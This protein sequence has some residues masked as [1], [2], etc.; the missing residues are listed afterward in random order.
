MNAPPLSRRFVLGT[1]LAALAVA[2]LALPPASRAQQV[3]RLDYL[4]DLP[5]LVDREVFFG[6]PETA[7]GQISPDGEHV[8]FLQEKDGVLNVWVKGFG[9]PF[10]AA[11][12][13]TA[14]TTRPVRAYFW[15]EDGETILYAQDKGG[16][17]DFHVYAVDPDGEPEPDTGVPAATDL[18]PYEDV[19]ARI[20][21][22]PENDPRHVIVGINDRDA[23]VHDV[24]RVDIETGERELVRRNEEGVAGWQTDLEGNLRLAIRIDEEGNTEIS[25]VEPDSL[26]VVYTCSPEE[27][28]GPIRFHVDGE[29]VYMV[30]NKG[31]PDLMRLVLFDP[32]TGETELVEEDPEGEVDFGG[33]LFS[34]ETEQLIATSYEDERTRWYPKDPAFERD[35]ERARAEFGDA[36][37][38]F[39]SMTEDG[40]FMLVSVSSDVAPSSTWT[41]DRESGE[42]ELLYRTR[43]DVPAGDMAPMEAVTYTARDGVEIPAFLTLPKGVEAENLAVVIHPHGGPWARDFWGYDGTVQF[44]ANR[45]YAVL[46]PNFRG[47]AGYG[48]RFLNL[49]N[50]EWGTGDMQHDITDGVEWL[51][52]RGVADPDRV[53]I[54]GGSYG[55]Y[56]TLAGLAFT[57]EL[58]AAGVDI[59]GPSSIITLLESIPP[60]W[61]PIQAIF[62]VRVGDPED[63]EDRER[64][65]AQSPLHFAENITAP[66][67]VIQGENDP[68]VKKRESDQI[69]TTL[70]DLGR[71]VEYM[72]APDEGH[73]FANDD[74]R[75]AMYVKIEEFLAEHLGGRYQPDAPPEIEERLAT[76]MVEVDTLTVQELATAEGAERIEAFD[77]EKV[78]PASLT[79]A[80]TVETGGRTIDLEATRTIAETT[81][82]GEPALVVVDRAE[83]PMGSAVDSTWVDPGT[84]VPIRRSIRQG[85]ATI[86]ILFDGSAVTGTIEAGP[87]TLPIDAS[88]EGVVFAKGGALE[89]GVP[90]LEL[91][92]GEAVTVE[93]FDPLAGKVKAYRLEASAAE[94]VETPGGAFETVRHELSA[95]D[96]SET[97]TIWVATDPG[98]VVRVKADLPAQM[99]G[100]TATMELKGAAE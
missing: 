70:R 20:Y 46:Q 77:G 63:P 30:T 31:E 85:P 55:G 12:P 24:Y 53:A 34:E 67:L 50:E 3:E 42:F 76:L 39:R 45:G 93:L 60:Y 2:T 6:N 47:S 41:Y 82:E 17:E 56:A 10:E 97:Q 87:Q 68:R 21:A 66:L 43:P 36:D 62:D 11:R 28:C 57:P 35:L 26:A 64:L 32:A 61:K 96:G 94:S 75:L 71:D 78:E 98:R 73:G 23:S 38:G 40:R 88:G 7:G 19:Q 48:E 83:S 4:E 81:W 22:V 65:E 49:G 8:S 80:Q 99:G 16:D 92:P 37:L 1:V 95:L 33:T 44:L 14:D 51:V 52:D 86:E 18:T 25:R 79:Y 90:T 69:V 9:E 54:M 74:N 29:R 5:P 72:V 58:Y 89:A 27:Q 59:V 100:G 13:V 91:E 84:L 15:S